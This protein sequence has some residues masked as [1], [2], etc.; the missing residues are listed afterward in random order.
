MANFGPRPQ[1]PINRF[2]PKVN[3]SGPIPAARPEL[4]P[5]WLWTKGLSTAGYGQFYILREDGRPTHAQAHR[6]VWEEEQGPLDKSIHLDH[7]CRVRNCVRQSHLEPVTVKE[8]LLRGENPKQVTHRTKI[9][10]NGHR[11]E[12]DNAYSW[13]SKK[14]GYTMTRCRTC[15]RER[16]RSAK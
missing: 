9:C 15:R 4:G 16:E 10:Q 12:G 5:C 3:K 1:D 11:I 2:W 7:L 13:T 6:W 14:R 8:N